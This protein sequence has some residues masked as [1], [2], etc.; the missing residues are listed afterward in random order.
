MNALHVLSADVQDTVHIGL[1][2]GSRIVVGNG[3]HLPLIQLKGG[4]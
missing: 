2:E 3:L 4:L 1:K